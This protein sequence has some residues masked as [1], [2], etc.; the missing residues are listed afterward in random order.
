MEG[1]FSSESCN[2][3]LFPVDQCCVK[4]MAN[5][6]VINFVVSC[7]VFENHLQDCLFFNLILFSFTFFIL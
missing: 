6:L 4:I 5:W 1:V 7:I 3:Q 2:G